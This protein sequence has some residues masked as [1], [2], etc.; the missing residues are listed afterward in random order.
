[1]HEL[2]AETGVSAESLRRWTAAKT[3]TPTLVP[4]EVVDDRADEQPSGLRMITVAGHRFE[5]LTIDDAIALVRVL[6]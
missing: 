4:I 6:G 5:G 3:A 1:L 2:S